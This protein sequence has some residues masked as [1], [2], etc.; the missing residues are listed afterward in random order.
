MAEKRKNLVIRF[1]SRLKADPIPV[2][3]PV[4]EVVRCG[5]RGTYL[6]IGNDGE[7]S[8]HCYGWIGG[9]ATLRKL[10]KAILEEVGEGRARREMR[11]K[12]RKE[13]Q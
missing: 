8:K 6:W 9:S 4:I 2:E 1:T 5:K 7:K 11:K 10:A 13:K 3:S 12:Q